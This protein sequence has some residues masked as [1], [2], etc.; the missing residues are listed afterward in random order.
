MKTYPRWNIHTTE[1][2]HGRVSIRWR[3]T[4]H[5]HG[6]TYTQRDIHTEGHTH[7][8][9]SKGYTHDKQEHTHRGIYTQMGLIHHTGGTSRGREM[10]MKGT[11]T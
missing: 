4:R 11:Y 10:N 5:T 2:T 8:I 7:D 6:W 9:H 1:C 3:H